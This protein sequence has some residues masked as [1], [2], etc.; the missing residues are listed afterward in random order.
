MNKNKAKVLCVIQARMGSERLPGKVMMDI[1]GKPVIAHVIERLKKCKHL[2]GIVLATSAKEDDRI[3]L[4][5][6][7]QYDIDACAGSEN[8]VLSRYVQ[9]SQRFHGDI[10]VRVTGDCPLI[11]P[12]IVDQL[13]TEFKQCNCDYMRLDVPD[14]YPRGLD[15]EIF[16][17]EAL[18]RANERAGGNGK[19]REHVTLIMYRQPQ[20]FS[21]CCKKAPPHLTRPQYRFCVDTMEDFKLVVSI[22]ENI[23]KPDSFIR[24]ADIVNFLDKNPSLLAINASIHQRI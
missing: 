16:T 15:A 17:F 22:F 11:D 12:Y 10:I 24:A 8:D 5:V 20:Y 7:Q 1:C 21:I 19:Y 14:T 9:A 6:A 23:Y 4:D 18:K 13:I 3:L 2:D